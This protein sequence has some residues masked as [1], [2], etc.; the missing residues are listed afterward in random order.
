MRSC[1]SPP[2]RSLRC[3]RPATGASGWDSA[4]RPGALSAGAEGSVAALRRALGDLAD[5][6]AVARAA[7]LAMRAAAAAPLE[8]RTIFAANHALPVPGAPLE[9][10]WHAATSMR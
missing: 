2:S 6:P 3:A 5:G 10:L 8:G 7:E 1:T 4:P 9:R